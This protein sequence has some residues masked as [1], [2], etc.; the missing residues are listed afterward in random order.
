MIQSLMSNQSGCT[1]CHCVDQLFSPDTTWL[2]PRNEAATYCTS[3]I[4]LRIASASSTDK[5]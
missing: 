3:G 4:S 2:P 5:V 1:P